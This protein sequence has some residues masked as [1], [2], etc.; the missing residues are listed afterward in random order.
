MIPSLVLLK[1]TADRL[2]IA[3][4]EVK[5]TSR[6]CYIRLLNSQEPIHRDAWEN[7]YALLTALRLSEDTELERS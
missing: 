4:R 5:A 7:Y 3:S 1:N 2:R 6:V